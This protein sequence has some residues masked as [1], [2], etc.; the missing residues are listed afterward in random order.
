MAR[1]K[2]DLRNPIFHDDKLARE[3]LETVL[4]RQG[5]VCPRLAHVELSVPGHRPP[6]RVHERRAIKSTSTMPPR[7]NCVTP[8]VVRA[9]SRSDPKYSV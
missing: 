3:Y 8:T 1:S 5:R 4:W 6:G 9:G 7:A 2:T